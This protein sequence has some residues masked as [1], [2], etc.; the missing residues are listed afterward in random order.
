[1]AAQQKDRRTKD[2][3]ESHVYAFLC[4]VKLELGCLDEILSSSLRFTA[5][6]KDMSM[7]QTLPWGGSLEGQKIIVRKIE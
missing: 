1:M 4:A 3:L 2:L 7:T 6:L 5:G